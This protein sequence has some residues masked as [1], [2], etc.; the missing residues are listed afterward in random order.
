M[1]NIIAYIATTIGIIA[2]AITIAEQVLKH[3]EIYRSKH[4]FE[5]I[6][7]KKRKVVEFKNE[8]RI[9]KGTFEY[10]IEQFRI[11]RLKIN[12]M[13]EDNGWLFIYNPYGS[14]LLGKSYIAEFISAIAFTC[15]IVFTVLVSIFAPISSIGPAV[16][17]SAMQLGLLFVTVYLY[18]ISDKKY[19]ILILT[20]QY[21]QFLK[22]NKMKIG[23]E[24]T[25]IVD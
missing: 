15:M 10:E 6:L 22:S 23:Q 3:K 13:N 25:K 7:E 12:Y 5:P 16:M 14:M 8:N 20:K 24:F 18:K 4:G 1:E 19:S 2:A 9:Q 11:K 17:I 21:Y